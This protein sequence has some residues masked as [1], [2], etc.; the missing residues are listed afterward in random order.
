MRSQILLRLRLTSVLGNIVKYTASHH[1]KTD[2]RQVNAAKLFHS[3]D[4]P[5]KRHL[6][7][8]SQPPSFKMSS[9]LK[10]ARDGASGIKRQLQSERTALPLGAT[11]MYTR[12]CHAT[13]SAALPVKAGTPIKGL[14]FFKDKDQV[15]ALERG[16]Y[17]NFVNELAK[18]MPSLAKLRRMP[19][20]EADDKLKRRYLKLQRRMVVKANNRSREK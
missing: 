10:I 11:R 6:H 1:F 19:N 12:F 15:V 14:D 17:P 7:P 13:T 18:P 5:I 4:D 20:E 3:T 16:E 8:N 2:Q 9:L